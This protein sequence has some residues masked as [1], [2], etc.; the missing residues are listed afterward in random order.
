MKVPG[1]PG[2]SYFS[3][4]VLEVKE[5]LKGVYRPHFGRT[6]LLRAIQRR[7]N[8]FP[9]TLLGSWLRSFVTKDRLTG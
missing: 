4:A 2:K 3:G 7:K 5:V 8:K 1:E 9:F 6:L